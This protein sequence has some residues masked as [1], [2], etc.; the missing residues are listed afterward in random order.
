M[1]RAIAD[2]RFAMAEPDP[3]ELALF[4]ADPDNPAAYLRFARHT[5]ELDPDCTRARLVEAYTIRDGAARLRYVEETCVRGWRRL[6]PIPAARR[7][8]EWWTDARTRPLL[9]GFARWATELAQ[10]GNMEKATDILK[11]A[12]KLDPWDRAGVTRAL[13]RMGVVGEA[14]PTPRVRM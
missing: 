12:V 11:L 7:A 9:L 10:A 1:D 4:R 2:D 3:A 13:K 6:S 8:L 14:P 5:L